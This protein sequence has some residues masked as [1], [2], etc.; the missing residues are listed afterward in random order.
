MCQL[1][2]LNNTNCIASD[3]GIVESFITAADN[4]TNIT[5]NANEEI[6]A[7]TMSSPATNQWVRYQYDTDTDIPY[8]NQ[9]GSRN[10]NK[11]VFAKEALL[12][13]TGLDATKRLA[14]Q[15]LVNCC[16]GLAAIHF[17]SNGK[18]MLQGLVY[19]S[20][21]TSFYKEKKPL[22]VTGNFNTNTG[23]DTDVV[24]A[25]LLSED[26]ILSNYVLLTRAAILAL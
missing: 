19:D 14:L 26:R 25:R 16:S 6:T 13:F 1:I 23:A 22:K 24:E 2:G 15:A 5:V 18:S 7:I 12:P 3:G 17:T 9:V 20:A 11:H 10:N 8:F 4:I 21:T